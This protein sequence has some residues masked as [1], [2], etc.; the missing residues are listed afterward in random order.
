MELWEKAVDKF[1]E[2][3]KDKEEV[4]GALVCG[5]YVTGDPS[6]HSD[7]DLHIVLSNKATRRIRGN[8]MVDDFLIEY[9]INPAKQI[10]K[11]FSEDFY[12]RRPHSMVQFVTGRVLFDPT[13]EIERLKKLA[14]EWIRKDREPLSRT[15]VELTKYHLWDTRD[16]LADCYEQDRPDFDFLYYNSLNVLY[17]AYAKFL[18]QDVFSFYQLSRY[19]RDPKF[20][21]KYL[22]ED[23]PDQDFQQR[24]LR[25]IEEP[26]R[27]IRMKEYHKLT[28]RVLEKMGGF[29]IDGW[30]IN[31]PVE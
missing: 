18:N 27:K 13:G 2:K 3:W 9:F 11:Y 26:A 10:E 28:E 5:S 1:L 31:T 23:F 29:S 24:F 16:N 22:A 20:Q 25:C 19:L 14:E 21:K 15:A 7:I 12:D 6:P 8:I 4:I 30:E 17:E